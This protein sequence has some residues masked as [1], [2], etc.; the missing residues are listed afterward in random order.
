LLT[1]INTNLSVTTLHCQPVIVLIMPFHHV[2][3]FV[4]SPR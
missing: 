1:N 2:A 4:T 3:L